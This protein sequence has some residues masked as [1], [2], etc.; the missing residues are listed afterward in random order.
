MYMAMR[1]V[2]ALLR[3]LVTAEATKVCMSLKVGAVEFSPLNQ[4]PSERS[5]CWG[6][7]MWMMLFL[8]SGHVIVLGLS[9]G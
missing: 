2:M 3:M 8:P 9:G 6:L 1:S 5:A 4:L 7:R